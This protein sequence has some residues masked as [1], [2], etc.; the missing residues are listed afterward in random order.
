MDGI[1]SAGESEPVSDSESITPRPTSPGTVT[2]GLYC[3]CIVHRGCAARLEPSVILYVRMHVHNV[4]LHG[5]SKM[6]V[7]RSP[8]LVYMMTLSHPGLVSEF[9]SKRS[10]V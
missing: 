6:I 4:F 7:V 8:N 5:N 9:G 3:P 10:K 1:D 2:Q